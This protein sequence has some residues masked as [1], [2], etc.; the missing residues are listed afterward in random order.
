MSDNLEIRVNMKLTLSIPSHQVFP[1][2]DF[3]TS[4]TCVKA[5]GSAFVSPFTVNNIWKHC[6][7]ISSCNSEKAWS[8]L[9]WTAGIRSNNLNLFD[10]KIP[11]GSR[12][13]G[14]ASCVLRGGSLQTSNP[15]TKL[16]RQERKWLTVPFTILVI[17]LWPGWKSSSF[18]HLLCWSTRCENMKTDVL[19]KPV[20][21]FYTVSGSRNQASCFPVYD[22]YAKLTASCSPI[23]MSR[24]HMLQLKGIESKAYRVFFLLL[25]FILEWI[26]EQKNLFTY[27]YQCL[28]SVS[29]LN[30]WENTHTHTHLQNSVLL[31]SMLLMFHKSGIKLKQYNI[32]K[33]Q[34]LCSCPGRTPGGGRGHAGV[35]TDAW[36]GWRGMSEGPD[37][38][39]EGRT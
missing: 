10:I 29:L 3:N 31:E 13:S 8:E 32:F 7:T 21:F 28:Q 17:Y 39:E 4:L 34:P 30:S 24:Q 6:Y 9:W 23:F 35:C 38:A 25:F 36:V 22:L 1:R 14:E 11:Q 15:K 2:F 26:F 19:K 5:F 18:N 33:T 27:L 37:R 20:H 12:C 16:S